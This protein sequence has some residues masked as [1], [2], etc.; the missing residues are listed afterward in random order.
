M[1]LIGV[2]YTP[3]RSKCQDDR[4]QP[5]RSRSWASR[6]PAVGNVRPRQAHA[7]LAAL[8]LAPRREQPLRRA[9]A[10]RHRRPRRGPR[11]VERRPTAHGVLDHRPRTRS[12][13]GV[14]RDTT[15][16]RAGRVGGPPAG[17][18]TQTTAPRT[19]SS[20]RS[21]RSKTTHRRRSTTTPSSRPSTQTD[22]DSSHR[23]HVNALVASLSIEQARATVR[24]ARSSRGAVEAWETTEQPDVKWAAETLLHAAREPQND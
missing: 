23:I 7:A 6:S 14:A 8:L 9:Q 21:S 17:C 1:L 4:S 10:A 2:R 18:S 24:W 13:A 3:V 20:G 19:T 11:G 16:R 12:A 15:S 5:R 22:R